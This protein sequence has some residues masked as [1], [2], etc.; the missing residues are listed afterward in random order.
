MGFV[1]SVG[2][3]TYIFVQLGFS[4]PNYDFPAGAEKLSQFGIMKITFMSRF[5]CKNIYYIDRFHD[6]SSFD[7]RK[8]IYKV[9]KD[10]EDLESNLFNVPPKPILFLL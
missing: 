2:K 4:G 8:R 6:Y 5:M 10:K 1:L 3:E 9:E 7:L